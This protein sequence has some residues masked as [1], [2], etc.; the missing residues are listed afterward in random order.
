[1][2]RTHAFFTRIRHRRTLG[3][4]H[5]SGILISTDNALLAYMCDFTNRTHILEISSKKEPG[6][7]T[8]YS[9]KLILVKKIS[10]EESVR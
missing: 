5:C 6:L 7:Y 10:F 8:T 2:K 3:A 4:Y 1:M 9:N